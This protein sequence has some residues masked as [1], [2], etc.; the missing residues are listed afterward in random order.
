MGR[1]R[2][3]WYPYH[4]LGSA[5]GHLPGAGQGQLLLHWQVPL[6]PAAAAFAHETQGTV[7]LWIEADGPRGRLRSF[8]QHA[9]SCIAV[10]VAAVLILAWRVGLTGAATHGGGGG[11]A[12]QF[13][14]QCSS[15]L[16]VGGYVCVPS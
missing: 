2:Q 8:A 14:A 12:S 15:W 4:W 6:Q 1:Q 9:P 10:R 13:S 16:A 7:S 5:H 3:L 11:G